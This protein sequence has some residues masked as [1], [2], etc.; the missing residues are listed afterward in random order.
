MTE[1]SPT[2]VP[3]R[4]EEELVQPAD[5]RAHLT[6]APIGGTRVVLLWRMRMLAACLPACQPGRR[7]APREAP[8]VWQ[9]TRHRRAAAGHAKSTG[10]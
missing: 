5:R 8:C 7:Q 4:R 6:G 3:R 10:Q 9:G 2:A 1:L